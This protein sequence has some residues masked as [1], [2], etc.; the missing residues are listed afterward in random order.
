[1]TQQRR[2]N[3]HTSRRLTRRQPIR[4]QHNLDGQRCHLFQMLPRR[5]ALSV[6]KKTKKNTFAYFSAAMF[7]FRYQI[8]Y[9]SRT[10]FR[11]SAQFHFICFRSSDS[12]CH[13]RCKWKAILKSNSGDS[14]TFSVLF[15]Y[16]IGN[17][18][19]FAIIQFLLSFSVRVTS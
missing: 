4:G 7:S 10:E 14:H 19:L 16:R 2:G 8:I 13:R 12:R 5:C 9:F 17:F 1:M 15:Y 11:S 6:K 18:G 3:T